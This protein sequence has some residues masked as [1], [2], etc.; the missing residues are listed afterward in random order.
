MASH[1][2]LWLKRLCLSN[3]KNVQKITIYCLTYSADADRIA[4]AA[5]VIS[6]STGYT[7]ISIK[8]FSFNYYSTITVS[9]KEK[10]FNI[11][12]R[13]SLVPLIDTN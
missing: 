5:A 2:T 13:Q 7:S 10:L 1:Y 8:V 6:T 4:S 9:F 11:T 3:S 12:N